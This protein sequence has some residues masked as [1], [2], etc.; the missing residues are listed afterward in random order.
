[1]RRI[2]GSTVWA[3]V[4]ILILAACFI[5]HGHPAPYPVEVSISQAVQSLNLPSWLIAT[6]TF[7]AALIDPVNSAIALLILFTFMLTFGWYRQAAF[8]IL[9]VTIGNGI[10]ALLGDYVF[11]PRPSMKYIKHVEGIYTGNSFPSGHCA[12]TMLFYGSLLYLSFR[13]P[14]RK[15]RYR[16]LLIPLQ[17]YAAFNILSIAFERIYQGEHWFFDT[18]SGTVDGLLWLTVGIFLY[19]WI[20]EFLQN[21]QA[22]RQQQQSQTA[23][24]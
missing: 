15:W 6:L 3:I 12:H 24:A 14:V 8:F 21:R 5:V 4:F 18:V 9:T 23:S 10:D 22:K 20:P 1:M 16:W 17:I 2:T 11:R 7:L 19:N 13:E